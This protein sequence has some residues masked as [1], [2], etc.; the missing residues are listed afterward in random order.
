MQNLQGLLAQ[1]QG[2]KDQKT[3]R[4]V[5][6]HCAL[7]EGRVGILGN[8]R[9]SKCS[10]WQSWRCPARATQTAAPPLARRTQTPP[11]AQPPTRWWGG[12]T[13]STARSQ[14]RAAAGWPGPVAPRSRRPSALQRRRTC[15]QAVAARGGGGARPASAA[16]QRSMRC[17]IGGLGGGPPENSCRQA[18]CTICTSAASAGIFSPQHSAPRIQH[19]DQSDGSQLH[20]PASPRLSCCSRCLRHGAQG[21]H[22]AAATAGQGHIDDGASWQQHQLLPVAAAVESGGEVEQCSR[23][24]SARQG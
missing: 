21:D 2:F 18:R 16:M 23:V 9:T 13:R 20:P 15:G 1:S 14:R 5:D 24:G 10:P 17:S 12:G 8:A 19:A 22:I 4:F 6:R 3:C 11:P 7:S